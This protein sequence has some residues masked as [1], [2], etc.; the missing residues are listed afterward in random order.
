MM[1][2]D[3]GLSTNLLKFASNMVQHCWANNIVQ[4]LLRMNT[5][6]N[7]VDLSIS[8][9]KINGVQC[10]V[11]LNTMFN[12]VDLNLNLLKINVVQCWLCLNT[13]LNDVAL[14]FK[15]A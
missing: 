1:Q 12:D 3:V 6:F 9:L 14:N 2:E 10:W 4:Y 13:M 5:M 7:D 8:L 11:H 15:P